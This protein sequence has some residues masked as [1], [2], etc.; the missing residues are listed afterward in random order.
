MSQNKVE[1]YD[2]VACNVHMD[3]ENTGL[4]KEQHQFLIAFHPTCGAPVHDLYRQSE[5]VRM[6]Q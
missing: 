1:I 5:A 6:Q 4:T 2:L 3:F